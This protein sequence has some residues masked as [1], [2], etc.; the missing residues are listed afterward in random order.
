MEKKYN[1]ELQRKNKELASIQL[2]L[3]RNLNFT[4]AILSTVGEGIITINELGKIINFN[5]TAANIFCYSESEM[6]GMEL[7]K[8]MPPHHR[9][10]YEIGRKKFTETVVNNFLGQWIETKGRRKDGSFFPMELNITET[11]KTENNHYFTGVLKDI[12]ERKE[13]ERKL[14]ERREDLEKLVEERTINLKKINAEL[15][16]SNVELEQFAYIASHD[17]QE[18]LRTITSFIQLLA[19]KN[20]DHFDEDSTKYMDFVVSGAKRMKT[21]INALLS[22]SHVGSGELEKN[23][24]RTEEALSTAL[25]SLDAVIREKQVHIEIAEGL[26][27][28]Y[29]D[30]NL[31]IQLF[32]NLIENGIKFCREQPRITIE[33]SDDEA[34][35]IIKIQDNGIGIADEFKE[36]IFVIFK[37]LHNA[38]E[39]H[40]TGIGLSVCKKIMTRHSGKISLESTPGQG[41]SFYLHFP[42]QN[43]HI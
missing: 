14:K 24:F 15:E 29:G 21:L 13:I 17:L 28:L 19:R 12:S 5:K 27:K 25:N 23:A 3:E 6:D 9:K 38:E 7:T 35:D 43:I 2:E 37:R 1:D 42:K 22:Y 36:K 30:K 31:I 18:P 4:S 32:Q 41:T 10:R 39:Y 8:L 26:G 11:L 33:Q 20:K 16:R 40:G 34:F